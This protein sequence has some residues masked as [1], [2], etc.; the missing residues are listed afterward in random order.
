MSEAITRRDHITALMMQSVIAAS[1][2]LQRDNLDLMVSQAVSLAEALLM[3]LDNDAHP[4]K[5]E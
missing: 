4:E 5:A 1:S 2:P 3:H